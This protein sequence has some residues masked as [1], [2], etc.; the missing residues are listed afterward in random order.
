MFLYREHK[1]ESTVVEQYQTFGQPLVKVP[2]IFQLRN[3]DLGMD[4]LRIMLERFKGYEFVD[5]S[6]TEEAY[7]KSGKEGGIFYGGNPYRRFAVGPI[8][9]ELIPDA[10]LLSPALSELVLRDRKLRFQSGNFPDD[11]TL[12]GACGDEDLGI[13]VFTDHRDNHLL[14]QAREKRIDIEVPMVFYH[15]K[16]VRD[17]AFPHGLRFDMDDIGVAFHVPVLKEAK[18]HFYADDPELVRTGFPGKFYTYDEIYKDPEAHAR[19]VRSFYTDG[20]NP[21]GVMRFYRLGNSLGV[22]QDFGRYNLPGGNP[23]IM[24]FVR[25][26]NIEKLERIIGTN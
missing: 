11:H 22:Q 16:T 17:E 18:H 6:P 21:S 20:S 2:E 24:S 4:V 23:M 8:V 19:G 15:L 1:M 9:R 10:K 25:G 12:Y 13:I 3:N 14:N 7:F 5:F 26:A